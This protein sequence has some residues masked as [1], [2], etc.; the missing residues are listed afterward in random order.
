MLDFYRRMIALRAAEPALV[1]GRYALLLRD[2]RQIYAY[3]RTLDGEGFVVMCNLT[4]RPARYRHAGFTLDHDACV[5]SNMEIA[6]HDKST[7]CA[8]RPYEARVYRISRCG[9]DDLN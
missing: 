7:A 2:N 1:H 9:P 5:L 6:P 3:T 8:L 4:N